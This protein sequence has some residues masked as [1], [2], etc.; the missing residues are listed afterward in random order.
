MWFSPEVEYP[1][2][3]S[4]LTKIIAKTKNGVYE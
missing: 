3:A 1:I 2:R 4:E